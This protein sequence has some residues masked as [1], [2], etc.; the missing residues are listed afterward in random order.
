M[1]IPHLK[2]VNKY[3]RTAL[4]HLII[5]VFTLAYIYLGLGDPEKHFGGTTMF[6]ILLGLSGG[7][8]IVA[9]VLQSVGASVERKR[10]IYAVTN[11]ASI[12]ELMT[13]HR[14]P[15]LSTTERSLIV[16]YLNDNVPGWSLSAVGTE[17]GR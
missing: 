7:S 13:M 14:S 15:E 9:L 1:Q 17:K 8:I 12:Q 16:Q 5:G 11:E 3:T 10:F 2:K 6:F 4:G